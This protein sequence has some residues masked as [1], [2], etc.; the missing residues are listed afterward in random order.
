[1][2]A[3][4]MGLAKMAGDVIL[5]VFLHLTTFCAGRQIFALYTPS[6]QSPNH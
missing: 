4:N 2:R 5:E 3:A 1:M 6:L